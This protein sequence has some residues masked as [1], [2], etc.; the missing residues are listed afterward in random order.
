MAA[1]VALPVPVAS[2][3]GAYACAVTDSTRYTGGASRVQLHRLCALPARERGATM[4]RLPGRYWFNVALVTAVQAMG[5][6]LNSPCW[7]E[8]TNPALESGAASCRPIRNST[9][10]TMTTTTSAAT[11]QTQV[12]RDLRRERA[13]AL[14][15]R[16]P[17]PGSAAQ[18]GR[19]VSSSCQVAASPAASSPTAGA[20]WFPVAGRACARRC[21]VP[22]SARRGV[23]PGP[24]HGG[25]SSSASSC[26][27]QERRPVP[28]DWPRRPAVG[29]LPDRGGGDPC[30]ATAPHFMASL[31]GRRAEGTP[32]STVHGRAGGT[33][34]RGAGG[35][36]SGACPQTSRV[37]PP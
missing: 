37:S 15:L 24:A 28:R 5:T 21:P 25:Y 20:A 22:R 27:S 3:L 30:S 36:G 4:R 32:A 34:Y 14:R 6:V 17:G 31:A 1:N 2:P 19:S 11:P 26:S 8:V 7:N 16:E 35:T 13:A 23:T 10:A 12:I 9:P 29:S 18:P 33:Q